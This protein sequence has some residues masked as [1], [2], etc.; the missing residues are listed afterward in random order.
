MSL[1][2]D[3]QLPISKI[4][5]Q[6]IQSLH[7]RNVVLQAEPGAGKSTGLPVVLLTEGWRG[8]ILL[9]EPRR[10]AAQNVAMRLS[11][12]LGEHLGTTIGLRMRGR[13]E[14]SS[15]TRLEVVTEGVLTRLLQEDPTLEGVSLVIFDEFHERSLHADLGL[16]LCL[17]VQRGLREDLRLL[18]MSATLDGDTLCQHVN[19]GQPVRCEVRQYPVQIYWEGEHRESLPVAV[20][21]VCLRAIKAHSGDTLVFLPGVAEIEKTARALEGQLVEGVDLH[22]LHGGVSAASQ[23]AATAPNSGRR[24]LILSTSIAET[25]ITIDGVEVVID[26]GLERRS[27]VDSRSG[28][29]RL[30]T[31]AS[32]QASAI[33]RTGRAGRTGAGVC[34]RLWNESS[35]KRR[36]QRWQPEILREDLS[37]LLMELGQWGLNSVATLPWVDNPPQS[38][39]DRARELLSSLDLWSED[40]LSA[41]G[42]LAAKLPL[43]PRMAHML[44]WGQARGVG[45][46]A[47]KVAALLE[48]RTQ[49]I[50][51]DLSVG[52]QGNLSK[53]TIVRSRQLWSMLQEIVSESESIGEK[54][55]SAILV[56]QAFPDRLAKRRSGIGARYHL[57]S[58]AGAV[59]HQDDTLASCEWLAVAEL[60]GTAKEAKI[61]SALALEFSE[62]QQWCASHI[63]EIERI[64][65]DERSER[66]LAERQ[67]WFS[68]LLILRKPMLKVNPDQRP[69]AL[70][71]AIR[72]IGL[73]CLTWNEDAREW[74]ARVARMRKLLI[75]KDFPSF[76]DEVLLR[77]LEK[78]LYPWLVN[79][80][81]IN[82][83]AQLDMVKILSQQLDYD[84]QRQLDK[85]LPCRFTVPSGS[86]IKLR[87]AC[88]GNPVL[89]V[90]L[91]EMF[92]CRENPSVAQGFVPLKVELLSPAQRPVQITE[93]LANF[94]SNSYPAVKK[95][96]AGRYPKHPWPDDPLAAMPTAKAKK[97]TPKN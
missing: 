91:Q 44:L 48:E 89:A 71:A 54:P 81:S 7:S 52:L 5:P 15:C 9:L 66:V 94:W 38:S 53:A 72:R 41:H 42:R 23:K 55:S 17:E 14:I 90:K 78:W 29:Q 3:L 10:L 51:S 4:A 61:F 2:D 79:I 36:S 63:R 50:G 37:S 77:T 19:A 45:E 16:A 69:T 1:L 83:L 97:R 43:H 46:L 58:G 95:D 24:R 12:L 20:A 82:A 31:V 33:Q 70:L 74:R 64:E 73:G 8:K 86:Q 26:S 11:Q 92:G 76:S 22:R 39:I 30:E 40:R 18:L 27:R 93:D 6:V 35:H 59:L 32:S 34:Y 96:L 68:S 88:S 57:S 62:I 13:T 60:G 65:W 67:W 49:K 75:G 87:Y 25:S 28:A 85:W 21:R 80:S 47:C 56:L 84:Q